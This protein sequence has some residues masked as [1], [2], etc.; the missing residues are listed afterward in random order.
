MLDQVKLLKIIAGQTNG[1]MPTLVRVLLG[2]LTPLYRL[3]VWWRNRKFDL[4]KASDDELANDVIRR[5]EV[6]VV[7][8]GNLTTGGTGKTPL[9]IW[10]ARYLRQSGLRVALVSRG[11]GDQG[12][13]KARRN[14]EAMELELRLPDVP[15]LQSPDRFAMATV[16]IEELDSQIVLLDDGFQ[17]RQLHRD[18]DIVLIDATVPF[19]FGRLLPRGLLREPLSSLKRADLVV[20]TRADQVDQ[21]HRQEIITKIRQH[22]IAGEI[23]EVRTRVSGWTR[24]SGESFPI[25]HLQQKKVFAFSGIGNPIGFAQTL[26]GLPMKVV[27]E[28][29]F[30]DHFAYSRDDLM[31]IGELAAASGA[32]AIVCTHKDLVKVNTNKLGLLPVFALV[33]DVEFI[34][35][36]AALEG[37]LPKSE[38]G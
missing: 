12:N 27:G 7:S 14:D 35:G 11:Y 20:L 24:A 34:S 23:A 6:P 32:E 9:V 8:V 29:Q 2:C 1:V 16:A 17:H 38:A 28:R 30:P 31:R 26:A 19:G 3:G 4:A 18:V 25:E 21:R 15:H 36:Q 33:V 5:V 10:I 22:F 37:L 13:A